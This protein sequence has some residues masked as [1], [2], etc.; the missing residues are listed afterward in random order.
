MPFPA[1]AAALMK[2]APYIMG[3]L[4][5]QGGGGQGG[6]QGNQGQRG[7][8][9][10]LT[11]LMQH[12]FPGMQRQRYYG[13][14]G[15]NNQF[16]FMDAIGQRPSGTQKGILSLLTVLNNMN[17]ARSRMGGGPQ[18][19]NPTGRG[20]GAGYGGLLGGGGRETVGDFPRGIGGGMG[21]MA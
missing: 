3:A 17:S 16:M 13:S 9:F 2:V 15:P 12:N 21:G 8:E 1:M 5:A 4:N 20:A 7:D 14:G 6:G 18:V 19:L 10:D 11:N